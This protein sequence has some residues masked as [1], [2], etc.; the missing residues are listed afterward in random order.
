M[1]FFCQFSQLKSNVWQEGRSR[2]QEGAWLAGGGGG[3][4]SINS[5]CPVTNSC[6]PHPTHQSQA[7][8][9]GGKYFFLKYCCFFLG[10]FSSRTPTIFIPHEDAFTIKGTFF[11]QE[12]PFPEKKCTCC[13]KYFFAPNT[14]SSKWNTVILLR[15]PNPWS[16][17]FFPWRIKV[18][19]NW[20]AASNKTIQ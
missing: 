2:R 12:I 13:G 3:G 9:P 16:K 6:N 14:F 5:C 7:V 10:R 4:C 18:S 17:A 20:C 11:Q 8:F 19:N 15:A 1:H